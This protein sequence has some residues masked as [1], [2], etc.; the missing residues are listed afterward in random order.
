[1]KERDAAFENQLSELCHKSAK[2]LIRILVTCDGKGT[3]AK[4]AALYI[5]TRRAKEGGDCNVLAEFSWDLSR[6]AS[7]GIDELP[8]HYGSG[9]NRLRTATCANP[10]AL[11]PGDVL[12]N[13]DVVLSLPK[14]GGNGSVLIHLTGGTDGHWISVPSRIPIALKRCVGFGIDMSDVKRE[15]SKS[16]PA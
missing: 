7:Y 13:D 10:S 12:I 16:P 3:L 2:E 6:Y 15:L 1:M 11:V 14:E 9:N 8:R 4:T 5:L